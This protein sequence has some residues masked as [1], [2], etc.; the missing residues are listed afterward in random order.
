[1]D[2]A[3]NERRRKARERKR[4]ERAHLTDRGMTRLTLPDSPIFVSGPF[5]ALSDNSLLIC[6]RDSNGDPAQVIDIRGWGH[7]TGEGH[8]ALALSNGRAVQLQKE[9]RDWTIAAM[10]E[11]WEKQK[12]GA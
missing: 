2:D 5:F 9:M 4:A 1:M 10:N 8:G 3:T 11:A 6:G 7:L 12:G